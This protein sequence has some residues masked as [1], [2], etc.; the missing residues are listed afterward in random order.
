MLLATKAKILLV[1][2]E[3]PA[4]KKTPLIVVEGIPEIIDWWPGEVLPGPDGL[5]ALTVPIHWDG[6][7]KIEYDKNDFQI[8]FGMLDKITLN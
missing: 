4:R 1:L 2:M 5:V 7:F 3:V 8:K 6:T